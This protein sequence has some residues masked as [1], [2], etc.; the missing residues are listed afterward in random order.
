M[1][2]ASRLSH[3]G[4]NPTDPLFY[5]S[6]I[7]MMNGQVGEALDMRAQSIAGNWYA[8]YR[9]KR[10]TYLDWNGQRIPYVNENGMNI[11]FTWSRPVSFHAWNRESGYWEKRTTSQADDIL[12]QLYLGANKCQIRKVAY[13]EQVSP[14]EA[15]CV[16]EVVRHIMHGQ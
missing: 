2:K 12:I 10:E 14:S 7:A 6:E 4:Y 8:F 11:A 16:N 9:G 13:E 3:Y 5:R 15:Q 1:Q